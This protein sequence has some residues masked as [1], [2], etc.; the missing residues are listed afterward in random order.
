MKK[1]T[2][3][4]WITRQQQQAAKEKDESV[5]L[6]KQAALKRCNAILALP[7]AEMRGNITQVRLQLQTQMGTL[8]SAEAIPEASQRL[9]ELEAQDALY[10]QLLAKIGPTAFQAELDVQERKRRKKES[11]G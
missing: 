8:K 10:K 6:A 5:R 9:G 1:Q 3:S 2:V 11:N 7:W 4:T